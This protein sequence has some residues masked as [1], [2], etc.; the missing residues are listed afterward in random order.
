MT[1]FIY[2]FIYFLGEPPDK[3]V[4]NVPCRLFLGSI[5]ITNLNLFAERLPM[6]KN[7]KTKPNIVFETITTSL[8]HH[9]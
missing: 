9:P 7:K 5:F 8:G 2:L 4:R 3:I 1:L 6:F